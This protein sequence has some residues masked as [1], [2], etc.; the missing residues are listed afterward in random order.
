MHKMGEITWIQKDISA[1]LKKESGEKIEL[2]VGTLIRYRGRPG[3]VK[4]TGFS[5]KESDTRGPIGLYYLPWRGNRW[6]EIAWTL[7]GNARHLI[8]FPVGAPHF[9]QHIDWDTVE[10][11]TDEE[12][13][14]IKMLL[15]QP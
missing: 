15:L 13:L 6:A 3:G 14:Q 11:L 9:G 5:S 8:A 1:E 7:R 10:L 12:A 4:I 2:C